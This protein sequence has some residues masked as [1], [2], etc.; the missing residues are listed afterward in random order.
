M[1]VIVMRCT[2]LRD[3]LVN[4]PREAGLALE[5]PLKIWQLMTMPNV[6]LI[7]NLNLF[8]CVSVN[9]YISLVGLL[10][11]DITLRTSLFFRHLDHFQVL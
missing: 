10:T 9:L 7:A 6:C 5:L 2:Q 3:M 11:D 1:H 4:W 8:L